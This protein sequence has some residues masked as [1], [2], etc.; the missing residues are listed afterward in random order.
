MLFQVAPQ[1][2]T[3]AGPSSWKYTQLCS[4][5]MDE[6][7]DEDST[8][9]LIIFH[10]HE[11]LG[12]ILDINHNTILVHFGTKTVR[13]KFSTKLSFIFGHIIKTSVAKAKGLCESGR[14]E[15]DSHCHRD[16]AP[17]IQG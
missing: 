13:I 5:S 2:P 3:F 17:A 14:V 6:P 12:D 10:T 7:T 8:H 11:T 1:W 9:Y 4:S 16:P 15:N